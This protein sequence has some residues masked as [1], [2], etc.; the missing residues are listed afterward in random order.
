M[1]NQQSDQENFLKKCTVAIREQG[2][3]VDATRGTGIVVSKEGLVLTCY[4]VI[5]NIE[6]KTLDYIAVDIYFPEA[7]VTKPAKVMLEYCDATLDIGFLM[8]QDI[9]PSEQAVAYLTEKFDSSHKFLSYGFRK[10]DQ[11][12]GL[13]AKIEVLGRTKKISDDLTFS[14]E[15]IQIQSDGI[16]EG[17]SGSAVLDLQTDRVIGIV[18]AH[19]DAAG[20]VDTDLNFAIPIVSIVNLKATVSSVLKRTNPGLSESLVIA[21]L[22]P[23]FR[24]SKRAILEFEN[25]LG[26]GKYNEALQRSGGLLSLILLGS[27]ICHEFKPE[28]K[29]L[30]E[31]AFSNLLT[32][33]FDSAKDL[34][35]KNHKQLLDNEEALKDNPTDQKK[36][37]DRNKRL[38]KEMLLKPFEEN[39]VW[40]LTY[41][42]IPPSINSGIILYFI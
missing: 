29:S 40:E 1:Q 28:G 25:A 17:M 12:R 9:L 37:L 27:K 2:G 21:N 5:G 16:E 26:N 13:F 38:F 36:D 6:D 23:M 30:E 15:V 11:F 18:F 32:Y 14:Q 33:L 3:N 39:V 42:I 4:H 41:R 19:Y 24:S 7:N 8:L 10:P 34:V 31:L 22:S 20:T 35:E